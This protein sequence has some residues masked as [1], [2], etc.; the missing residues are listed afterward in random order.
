MIRG[1][2]RDGRY[3]P[4]PSVTAFERFLGAINAAKPCPKCGDPIGYE[5]AFHFAHKRFHQHCF[6]A[7]D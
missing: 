4:E 7:N 6:N 2:W 5:P 3:I 1:T